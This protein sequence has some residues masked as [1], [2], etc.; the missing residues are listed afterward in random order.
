METTSNFEVIFNDTR[1]QNKC[2][3]IIK[4]NDSFYMREVLNDSL[5]D[6]GD[7][8]LLDEDMRTVSYH[9]WAVPPRMI[10]LLD[11]MYR[12]YMTNIMNNLID[13]SQI[14][15]LS[16]TTMLFFLHLFL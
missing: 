12:T 15:I 14:S 8:H 1:Y 6:I 2:N 4:Y 13:F 11:N 16:T 10:I 7:W 9:I 3:K 5:F